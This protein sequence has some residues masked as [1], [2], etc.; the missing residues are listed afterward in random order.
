MARAARY[1]YVITSIFTLVPA[2]DCSYGAN[3]PDWFA[4]GLGTADAKRCR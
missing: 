2:Y 3:N 4:F 1:A